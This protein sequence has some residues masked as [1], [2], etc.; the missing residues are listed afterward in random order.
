MKRNLP[1]PPPLHIFVLLLVLGLSLAYCSFQAVLMVW[2]QV[3]QIMERQVMHAEALAT[4]FSQRLALANPEN[5]KTKLEADIATL[6]ATPPVYWSLVCD[7]EGRVL[8]SSKAEWLGKL[9]PE[10][11]RPEVVALGRVA[12]TSSQ[13]VKRQEGRDT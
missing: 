2:W 10:V 5:R 1:L 11:V 13:L 6:G 12:A 9:L 7:A 8:F 3:D 4:R